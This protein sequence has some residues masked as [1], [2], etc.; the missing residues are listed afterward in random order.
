ERLA[1][2]VARDRAADQLFL[3]ALDLSWRAVG[4]PGGDR[5]LALAQGAG[6]A[7]PRFRL[8][9]LGDPGPV[10]GRLCRADLLGGVLPCRRCGGAAAAAARARRSATGGARPA[11]EHTVR[12]ARDYRRTSR[13]AGSDACAIPDPGPVWR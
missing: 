13:R 10:V 5:A 8:D 6:R 12:V 2:P 4:L 11:A 9:G 1:D 7:E 3:A